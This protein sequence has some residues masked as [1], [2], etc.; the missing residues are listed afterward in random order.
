M[1][2]PTVEPGHL[3]PESLDAK[4]T[5][6][7]L[8][9]GTQVAQARS[10]LL[11]ARVNVTLEAAAEREPQSPTAPAYR[12]WMADNLAQDSRYGDALG[13]YDKAV[14]SAIGRSIPS[15]A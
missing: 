8:Q 3:A 13:A 9:L 12:L 14:N 11:C 15:H 7:W 10:D 1:V 5:Y 4:A 2:G 6:E